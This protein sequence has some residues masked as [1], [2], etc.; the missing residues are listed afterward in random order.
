M[1]PCGDP[2]LGVVDV[3]LADRSLVEVVRVD[4]DIAIRGLP[5][6]EGRLGFLHDCV[7]DDVPLVVD[8]LAVDSLRWTVELRVAEQSGRGGVVP[9]APE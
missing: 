9:V 4:F 7:V 6:V 3:E 5:L 8:L 1:S 2:H